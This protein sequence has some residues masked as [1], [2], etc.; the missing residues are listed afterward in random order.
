MA[1]LNDTVLDQAL[2]YL[3][4]NGSRLDI[5][6]QE[7]ATYTEATSTYTLGNK[8]SIGW[9]GPANGD[10]SGRKTTVNAITDGS[11]TGTG[12][13][14]HWAVSKTT[15]TTALLAAGSLA[16]SQSVTSGNTFTLTA[17]DIEIPDAT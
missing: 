12:T 13:A 14:S 7:P 10:T 9:T 16:S 1:F 2:Q 15:A 6:S 11:V 4:D 17:F 8:T 5:C 3:E